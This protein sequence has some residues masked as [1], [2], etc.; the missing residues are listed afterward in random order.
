M[1]TPTKPFKVLSTEKKSHRTKAELNKRKQEESALATGK[2]LRERTD[3][4]NNPVAHAEFKRLNNLLKIIEKNDAIYEAVINRYCM[5]SAEC[6]DLEKK[7]E[8]FFRLIEELRLG[9][10][11]TKEY[12]DDESEQAVLMIEFAREIARIMNSVLNI[13]AAIHSKRKML[14]DLEKENV[15]TIAS[16]LRSIPKKVDPK[17]EDPLLKILRGG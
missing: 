3:I 6:H 11:D 1:P 9:F 5:I 17:E 4:K 13:D 8:E 7:R 10:N 2:A 12:I 14:F 15:M 16:A